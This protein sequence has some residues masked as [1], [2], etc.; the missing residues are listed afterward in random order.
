MWEGKCTQRIIFG[1][2]SL[3][4]GNYR[5]PARV[6]VHRKPPPFPI[7]IPISP[8]DPR[9]RHAFLRSLI[10]IH[11]NFPGADMPRKRDPT[12][13]VSRRSHHGC[14][15][16]RSQKIRCD[17]NRP[18]C[19][20]CESRGYSDCT[21][22]LRL[23]WETDYVGRAFG[24]TRVW[25][26]TSG[27]NKASRRASENSLTSSQQLT[28]VY[29]YGFLNTFS[30]DFEEEGENEEE[31][32]EQSAPLIK[33]FN[34]TPPM[35]VS[36][37]FLEFGCIE[38]ILPSLFDPY[39]PNLQSADPHLVS[40]FLHKICPLTVSSV[41]YA[42][43]SPFSSLI[44]PSALS[45]S[46]A[47][48]HGLL[49]LAA[50]HRARTDRVHRRAALDYTSGA[51]ASLR[52][53]FSKTTRELSID[54][55]VLP[56]MMLLCQIALMEGQDYIWVCHL[57]GARAFISFRRQQ[58]LLGHQSTDFPP[59]KIQSQDD[60][61]SNFAERFFAFYD[62]IGR[63]A[64]GE[65]PIF[66]SD[67]W[68]TQE[69]QVDSWMGCSPQLIRIISTI[70]EI[71][72][73]LRGLVLSSEERRQLEHR[74]TQLHTLL[75]QMGPGSR[76]NAFGQDLILQQCV[77]LKRLTVEVYLDAALSDTTPL[78]PS[79][80]QGVRKILCLLAGL[81]QSGVR[82]GLTWPLFMAACQLD[83]NEDLQWTSEDELGSDVPH[84]ARPFVLYAL[85]QLKTSLSN[86]TRTRVVIEKIWKKRESA[87][88]PGG[89]TGSAEGFNDWARFVAPLCHNISLA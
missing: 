37:L 74:R 12:K 18:T 62:V 40:Y 2:V 24:R 21:F 35:D 73:G 26:K 22:S 52:A 64:C 63:T 76:A 85:N 17:E 9:N 58:A 53:S 4:N 49:G 14:Q 19:G 15:R 55:V 70:T 10:P 56:L 36:T 46:P 25:S 32:A 16:C 7:L 6:F 42:T 43:E 88:Q 87:N 20:Y 84:Y 60:R 23:K 72:W 50:S 39:Q 34:G 89:R 30:V 86:V 79:I 33:A 54:P 41:N 57:Q 78:T 68:S 28:R 13:Q 61:M 48:M 44:L 65:E 75:Q 11:P 77:E 38:P 69:D 71:S 83:P 8:S 59:L 47:L 82:T 45:S 3:C 5:G 80:K 27:G 29:P 1:Q 81:L 67:F 31:D 51:L 66:G